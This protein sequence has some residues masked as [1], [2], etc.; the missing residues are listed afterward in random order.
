MLLVN[1]DGV[2]SPLMKPLNA[3]NALRLIRRR[4]ASLD[5]RAEPPAPQPQMPPTP[6]KH[7]THHRGPQHRD[8]EEARAEQHPHPRQ[9]HPFDSAQGGVPSPVEGREERQPL[10]ERADFLAP[11]RAHHRLR[12]A[13]GGD[14]EEDAEGHEG[15]L[16]GSLDTGQERSIYLGRR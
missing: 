8:F 15:Q 16:R 9:R 10:G 3:P 7:L 1:K 12:P 11:R 13:E 2:V 5:Q 14:G 4:P 6:W